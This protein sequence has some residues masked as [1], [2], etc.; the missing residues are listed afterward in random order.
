MKDE[1]KELHK[2]IFGH[3]VRH[4]S[5]WPGFDE[6]LTKFLTT[7][8]KEAFEA[9]REIV[10]KRTPSG[11]VYGYFNKYKTFEDYLNQTKDEE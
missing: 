9:A 10:E 7:I 8:K 1:I 5:F 6:E 4:T 2:I 3:Q 11:N